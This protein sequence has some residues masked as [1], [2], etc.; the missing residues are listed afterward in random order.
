MNDQAPHSI[1]Y[2]L[3]WEIHEKK[4]DG[5]LSA[6]SKDNK[7]YRGVLNCE[8]RVEA[9]NVMKGLID[10]FTEDVKQCYNQLQ[11]QLEKEA[12]P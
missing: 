2:W 1:V 3:K 6:G 4:F 8:N 5:Q 12:T 11:P 10:R 7:E 9:Q